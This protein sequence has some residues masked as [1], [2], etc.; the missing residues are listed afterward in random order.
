MAEDI[1]DRLTSRAFI[2]SILIAPVIAATILG[3]QTYMWLRNGVWHELPFEV[4]FRYFA[5]D[6]TRVYNP[7]EWYGV[8]EI[9]QEFLALPLS[10]CVPMLIVLTSVMIRELVSPVG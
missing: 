2:G 6:L 4:A 7:T 10:F 8:A 9:I 5:I 1:W 3:W